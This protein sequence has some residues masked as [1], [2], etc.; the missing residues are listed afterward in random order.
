MF[1]NNETIKPVP[2]QTYGN[3][4]NNKK[5][6]MRS[7]KYTQ[8]YKNNWMGFR[9]LYNSGRLIN[10]ALPGFHLDIEPEVL[11]LLAYILSLEDCEIVVAK[12]ND[13]DDLYKNCLHKKLD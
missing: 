12:N 6:K 13:I 4:Y 10:C 1:I 8:M 9:D 3:T 2:S 5:K 7:F 11:V